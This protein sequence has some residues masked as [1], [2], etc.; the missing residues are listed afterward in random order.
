MIN[1]KKVNE[2]DD[3][4]T[5]KYIFDALECEFDLDVA[6]PVDRTHCNVPAK[7]FMSEGSLDKD[8]KGFVWMNPPYSGR[9]GKAKWLNKMYAH[10]NGIALLPDSTSSNWWQMAAKQADCI[11][12]LKDRI[13]FI[14]SDGTIGGQ[15]ANGSCLFA[16]GYNAIMAII[17]AE[18]NGLGII[19]K[20]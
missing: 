12:F 1:G 9:N 2:N 7:Y 6:S 3:C 16:Y 20:R 14:Y 15:P 4:Y 18:T 11:L 10:G 19:L 13:K 5:P 8:W 17:K